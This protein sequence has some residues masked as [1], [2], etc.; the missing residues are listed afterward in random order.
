MH[1][2]EQGRTQIINLNQTLPYM[3][4]F[5]IFE[6]LNLFEPMIW[7]MTTTLGYL[8]PNGQL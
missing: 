6:V 2:P 1:E 3:D 8:A 5:C 4:L 7:T